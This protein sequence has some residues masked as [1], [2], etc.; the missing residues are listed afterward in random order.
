MVVPLPGEALSGL[1]IFAFGK[2]PAHGDF[3]ARGLSAAE[4][5]A[6]D[7]WASA[8]LQA[9]RYG[10]GSEFE[11]RHTSAPPW[12]FAFGPGA[13]G[14]GWRAGAFTPSV[15]RT[16]RR[17]IVVLG[18]KSAEPL[19]PGGAGAQVAEALEAEIYRAFE[20][21]A[22]ID[23]LVAGAQTALQGLTPDSACDELGRFWTPD[24][25]LSV[26]A[27]EP[28]GDLIVRALSV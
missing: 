9:A 16:G 13:F 14:E 5:Q 24:A 3:V 7:D 20:T 26:S 15:D 8:G 19:A 27:A 4:R 18:A 12:R 6:W 10:F 28:P 23:A 17:F 22:D 25:P 1:S 21:G 11:D 2:L